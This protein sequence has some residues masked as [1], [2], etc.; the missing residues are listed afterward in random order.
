MNT[1]VIFRDLRNRLLGNPRFRAAAGRIWP[2]NLIARRRARQLF[3]ISAGFVYSQVLMSCIE[4]GWFERL[5]GGPV[6]LTDLA[7]DARL[8]IAATARLAEAAHSLG[9]TEARSSGEIALGPLGA[10]MIGDEG[11]AAMATHHAMLYADMGSPLAMLRGEREQTA[12][13]DFWGYAVAD[14]P[15]ALPADRVQAYSAL[16]AASQPMIA[17]Q[18]LSAFDFAKFNHLLDVGGG[19]GAFLRA[20]HERYPG[21][22][23]SLFDLP[24]VVAHVDADASGAPSI[25]PGSFLADPLPADADLIS[26]IRIIHDHDDDVVLALLRNVRRAIPD[27]GTLLIAEP[28]AGTPGAEAVGGAYFGF[29]L[30]AMGSGRARTQAEIDVLLAASGFGPSRTHKTPIPLICSV[31]SVNPV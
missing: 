14:D 18:V 26:L 2:F 31:I 30:L 13:S 27:N 5:R 19:T 12:L 4:L 28:M 1:P 6:R 23:Q 16:M 9:L 29:Y 25:Y 21:L 3:D 8:T 15:S 24:G 7:D 22:R 10:S 17:E 20:V 11:I